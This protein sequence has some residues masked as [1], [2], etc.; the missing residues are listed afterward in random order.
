M[1]PALGGVGRSSS[2]R[3]EAAG[4]ARAAA[5]ATS[6]GGPNRASAAIA[7]LGAGRPGDVWGRRRQSNRTTRRRQGSGSLEYRVWSLELRPA[8]TVFTSKLQTLYSKL[9][10]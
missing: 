3:A 10:L 2:G 9:P 1:V 6:P 5:R 7:G 4:T 8:S